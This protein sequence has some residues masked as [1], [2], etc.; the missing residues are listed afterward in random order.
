MISSEN[1]V[2]PVAPT[3][4]GNDGCF[5]GNNGWWILLLLLFAGGFGNGFGGYGNDGVMP[6][7]WN[8]Q[9]QNDVNRGFEAAGL[10]SQ[11]TGIQSAITSGFA[12][13]EVARCNAEMNSMQTAYQNQI[14]SM[15]QRFADTQMING[16][17]DNIS[18]QLANCCC[19]NRLATCN[20][21]N[22]IVSEASKNREVM[23]AS[24][25]RILDQIC[26]DKIDSKN[27]K[28]ADL[29]RQ[30]SVATQNAFITQGLSNEVDQLYNRLS[31]CPVPSTPVYGR[32]PIFTPTTT[33]GTAA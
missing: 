30:L 2:M 32:T 6:Y 22:T 25:Q 19:E 12:N 26:Q 1:M 20:T 17:F 11:L 13:S 5:G 29:Q 14:A 27:E 28:I 31:N 18:A 9:T 23:L 24:T 15:N 33:T 16:G 3:G 8:A 7:M 10:S 21:N 4:Y